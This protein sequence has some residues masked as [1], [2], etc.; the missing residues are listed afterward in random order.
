MTDKA[1]Y[2]R[3]EA[4]VRE[5]ERI[6]RDRSLPLW[7]RAQRVGTAYTGVA[8]DGLRSNHR[9]DDQH[10]S[11]ERTSRS[12]SRRDITR[13]VRSRDGLFSI[14]LPLLSKGASLLVLPIL[15]VLLAPVTGLVSSSLGSGLTAQ[16]EGILAR[17]NR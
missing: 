6:A 3:W 12:M 4:S 1:A 13:V 15:D 11:G 8:L 7:E 5:V 17:G 10:A 16:A 14:P 9:T 2:A